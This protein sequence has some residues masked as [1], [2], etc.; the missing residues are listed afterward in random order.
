VHFQTHLLGKRTLTK[1][2]YDGADD[3]DPFTSLR[4]EIED[5]NGDP[6]TLGVQVS[7]PGYPEIRSSGQVFSG[8]LTAEVQF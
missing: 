7:N 2:I 6:T 8:G 3:Y 1:T 5:D 4:D